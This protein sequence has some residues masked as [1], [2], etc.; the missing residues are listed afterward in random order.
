MISHYVQLIIII[1]ILCIIGFIIYNNQE[2]L[3]LSGNIDLSGNTDLSG[4]IDLSGNTDT[5]DQCE[6]EKNKIIRDKNISDAQY[7]LSI[8]TEEQQINLL[9]NNNT[10]LRSEI[11][12]Y[13]NDSDIYKQT[14]LKLGSLYTNAESNNMNLLHKNKIKNIV[15]IV[16]AVS[17]GLVLIASGILTLKSKK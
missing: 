5:F 10:F 6:Y 15:I 13:K 17:L 9:T 14:S 2:N 7:K 3:D 16:L 12:G 8:A 1:I 11:A 4:N